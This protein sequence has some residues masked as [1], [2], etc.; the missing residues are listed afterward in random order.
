MFT[1]RTISL[2]HFGN[3]TLFRFEIASC[4]HFIFALQFYFATQRQ[5]SYGPEYLLVT[6]YHSKGSLTQFLKSNT[7][8]WQEM[9]SLGLSLASGLAYLHNDG[10]SRAVTH[11]LLFCAIM[12]QG[13]FAW[14]DAACFLGGPL[15]YHSP[16]VVF[17]DRGHPCLWNFYSILPA[18]VVGVMPAEDWMTVLI[19]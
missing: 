4:L 11:L 17:L 3:K 15:S 8:S 5:Q 18:D 2:H 14:Y 9:C 13:Q 12:Y 16:F 6:E 19:T 10:T 7:V 1:T